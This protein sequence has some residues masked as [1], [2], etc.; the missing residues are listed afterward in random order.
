MAIDLNKL[1]DSPHFLDILLQLEE[2]LDSLD[3]Y[4]YRNWFKGEVVAGP[5]LRRYWASFTLRYPEA[6]MPDPRAIPRLVRHGIKVAFHRVRQMPHRS[7]RA[8]PAGAGQTG[9]AADPT[10]VD[11]TDP[12]A[13]IPADPLGSSATQFAGSPLGSP[14]DNSAPGRATDM[15]EPNGGSEPSPQTTAPDQVKYF[16][17]VKITVPRRLLDQMTSTDLGVYDELVDEDEVEDAQDAGLAGT[18]AYQAPSD[19][20][21]EGTADAGTPPGAP[22]PGNM[23]PPGSAGMAP[24][25]R[26]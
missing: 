13:A 12:T 23:P 22:P 26:G 14:R 11:Q 4:V 10:M 7:A 6:K 21:P 20:P 16:W 1:E 8:T 24:P 25:G 17:M 19:T 9:A 18:A 15:A 5:E 2:V 3:I